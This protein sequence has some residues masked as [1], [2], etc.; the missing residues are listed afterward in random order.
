[1]TISSQEKHLFYSFRT[2]PRIWQHYFSKY[3]WGRMHGP[4]PT[5]NFFGGHPPSPP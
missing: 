5:S 1:M 2:F 3:W 4:S